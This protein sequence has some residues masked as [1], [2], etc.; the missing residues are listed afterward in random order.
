[1]P[2]G[3]IVLGRISRAHELSTGEKKFDFSTK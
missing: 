2:I 3:T 1:M